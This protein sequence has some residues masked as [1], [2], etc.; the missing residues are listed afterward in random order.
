MKITK[1]QL[2]NIIQQNLI[3]ADAYT[4]K[5]EKRYEQSAELEQ[6]VEVKE[7]GV[8]KYAIRMTDI[9]KLGI[10]PKYNFE[11]PRGIYAYPL[12]SFIYKNFLINRLPYA[13]NAENFLLLELKNINSWL[14]LSSNEKNEDWEEICYQMYS[15]VRS[16]IKDK[17]YDTFN[18]SFNEYKENFDKF[19][20]FLYFV[21]KRGI[22]WNV[23]SGAKVYDVSFFLSKILVSS[24]Y[25]KNKSGAWQKILSYVGYEGVYD[26]GLG[27]LHPNEKEQLVGFKKSSFDLVKVYNTNAVR[28]SVMPLKLRGQEYKKYLKKIKEKKIKLEDIPEI[29]LKDIF[30]EEK[31][32]NYFLNMQFHQIPK[33]SYEIA[34]AMF[35]ADNAYG[36]FI[37]FSPN[38][39]E[40]IMKMIA[41]GEES[42]S[43]E[44]I[45]MHPDATPE[46]L[47]MLYRDFVKGVRLGVAMNK[48]TPEDILKYLAFYDYEPSVRKAAKETLDK[49]L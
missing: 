24:G 5:F 9:P 34:K 7:N 23:S 19:D 40:D 42:Y 41:E 11:N 1:M 17:D 21:S 46:I 12:T 29:Y 16:I 27:I 48:N 28:R 6:Y 14:D 10:N 26:P 30:N 13:G 47:R 3:E 31:I 39:T 35:E 20:D 25:S 2:H 8:C 4:R 18:N 45:A 43:R 44:Q 36:L 15:Y 32:K 22:H 33:L 49:I 38:M 37:V